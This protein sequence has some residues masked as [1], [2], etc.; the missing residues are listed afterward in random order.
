MTVVTVSKVTG[1]AASVTG[2]ASVTGVGVSPFSYLGFIATRGHAPTTYNAGAKNSMSR[3]RHIAMDNIPAIQLAFAGY[4]VASLGE[5]A[6]G[7]NITYTASIEFP[8]GVTVTRVTFSGASS[9]VCTPGATLFSDLI[10]LPATIPRGESFFVRMFATTTGGIPFSEGVGLNTV[11]SAVPVSGEWWALSSGA[12]TDDTGT[13]NNQNNQIA[14][15]AG[16]QVPLALIGYTSRNSILIVGDSRSIGAG[17]KENVCNAVGD[18]GNVGRCVGRGFAYCSVGAGGEQ[19]A[20]VSGS[21]FVQRRLLAA[22]CTHIVCAYGINDFQTGGLSAATTLT[23]LATFAASFNPIKPFIVCTVEPNTTSTDGWG[24]VANQ[25][26]VS[27]SANT[28]R[29]LYNDS[30]RRG[31]YVTPIVRTA[32]ITSAVESGINSGTWAAAERSATDCSITSGAAVL[33]STAVA[34]FT[35][36]DVG[37]YVGVV[38]AGAAGAT[39]VT[40][41]KTYT[42]A[43]SVTLNANAGTTVGPTAT[44]YIG[45][46]TS[47]GI[48]GTSISSGR[49]EK[50]TVFSVLDGF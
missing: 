1:I 21:A 26:Q 35:P 4:N 33:T 7:A 23:N 10:A 12:V 48:H 16:M 25:S 44:A 8:V 11:T 30:L 27:S 46:P 2:G 5:A 31:N 34:Q 45:I 49:I 50:S 6:A 43:T 36:D 40:Y 24:T 38:G 28:Q 29:I 32:D 13:L 22:Y 19:L 47:D 42:S 20:T 3:S 18:G 17:L 9:G 15:N 39:L 41:I 14:A 37:K